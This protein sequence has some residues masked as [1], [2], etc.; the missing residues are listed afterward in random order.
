[1]KRAISSIVNNGMKILTA[2]NTH[3]VPESTNHHTLKMTKNLILL[4]CF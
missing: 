4:F 1:M 3:V 2:V